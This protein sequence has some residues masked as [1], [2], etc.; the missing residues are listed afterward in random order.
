MIDLAL[1]G[2]FTAFVLAVLNPLIDLIAMFMSSEA[3]VGS[4]AVLFSA[5]AVW[6]D[7][8]TNIKLFVLR[9]VAGAFLGS[10]FLAIAERFAKYRPTV[11]TA[12]GDR[13]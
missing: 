6:L 12:R 10:A 9:T 3:V 2:C 5:L 8:T 13:E 11:Y 1:I 7:G 4:I